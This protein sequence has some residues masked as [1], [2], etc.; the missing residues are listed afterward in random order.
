MF[1]LDLITQL[2]AL[3]DQSK[4]IGICAHQDPDGDCLGAA[5]GLGKYLTQQNKTIRYF[6]PTPPAPIFSFLPEI[7]Q[8]ENHIGSS[9]KP[10]LWINVDTATR[11]RSCLREITTN[12]PI[13]HIDHHTTEQ[14][15][16]TL[17]LVNDSCSSCSEQI[18]WLLLHHDT[19]SITPDIATAFF[20][21]LSTDTG[22]F[23]R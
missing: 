8:F 17:N 13:I 2:R 16:G 3:I 10:D 5:I 23:Q 6:V 4:T 21:G 22:H 1:S 12:T 7:D 20:L 18:A 14:P 19:H 9:R 15:R 11:E